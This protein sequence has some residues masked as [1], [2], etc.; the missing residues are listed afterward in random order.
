MSRHQ[1][2]TFQEALD[3]VESLP[4]NQQ[5]NLIEVI[6]HRLIERRREK[7]AEHVREAREEYRRGEVRQGTAD[8][9][10]KEVAE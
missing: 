10:I 6:Q 2:V 3:I 4:E 8:Y 5:E 1:I 9:L 7:L